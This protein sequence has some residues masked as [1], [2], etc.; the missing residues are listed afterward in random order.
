M[1]SES[2][3]GGVNVS[4]IVGD[5]TELDVDAFVFYARSDLKLGSGF[6]GAITVRGGSAIKDELAAK[7]SLADCGAVSTTAG[8][9]KAR[10]IIHANGPKF[11]EENAAAKLQTTM[12]NVFACAKSDSIAKIAFPPMGCGF[13]GI[14]LDLCAEVMLKSITG[15]AKSVGLKEVII[16][17]RDNREAKPFMDRLQKGK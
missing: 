16:C 8:D 9:L 3:T 7:G 10:R 13:Y 5:I 1:K 2:S 4:V 6:G 15:D 14:P 11:Q 17:A 12:Q